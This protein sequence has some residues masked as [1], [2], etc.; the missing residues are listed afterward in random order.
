MTTTRNLTIL[1]VLLIASITFA[2]P[3]DDHYSKWAA[4]G[5]ESAMKY[6]TIIGDENGKIGWQQPCT[7]ERVLHIVRAEN[8]MAVESS[9]AQTDLLRQQLV[10]QGNLKADLPNRINVDN[11]NTCTFPMVVPAAAAAAGAQIPL[12]STGVGAPPPSPAPAG[13][14][15]GAPPPAATTP[16]PAGTTT[17]PPPPATTTP[18]PP[19]GNTG[20]G[21]GAP[22]NP[23]PTQNSMIPVP[24]A[25]AI[26]A[27][28]RNIVPLCAGSLFIAVL[29][30]LVPVARKRFGSTP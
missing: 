21:T 22:T 18:P 27:F 19:A 30:V 5:A 12:Q 8:T 4:A 25:N 17:P 29:Y 1:A 24:S 2:N 3:Y 11:R 16:P 23:P 7:T 28:G 9:V 10:A 6:K 26:D 15:G 20:Q 14:Q 13:A